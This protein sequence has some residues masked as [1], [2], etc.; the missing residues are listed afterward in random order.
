[1]G[2][3]QSKLFQSSHHPALPHS[4]HQRRTLNPMALV[5][6]WSYLNLNSA[7]H[8]VTSHDPDLDSCTLHK[9]TASSSLHFISLHSPSH[10]ANPMFWVFITPTRYVCFWS[11]WNHQALYAPLWALTGFTSFYK[12]TYV[13]NSP[14]TSMLPHFSLS[15]SPPCNEPLHSFIHFSF[16]YHFPHIP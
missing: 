10:L 11:D 3:K 7:H 5:L 15:C 14:T 6:A 9:P 1:M 13:P 4:S 16:F 8:S 12:H 2:K